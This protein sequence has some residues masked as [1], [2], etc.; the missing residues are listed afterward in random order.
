METLRKIVSPEMMGV[1][2]LQAGMGSFHTTPFSVSHS[3]GKPVSPL[4]PSCVGPRQ[5]GQ[6]SA[7]RVAGRKTGDQKRQESAKRESD[8]GKTSGGAVHCRSARR[9]EW[10]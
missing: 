1:A 10:N 5:W 8:H 7:A 9:P 6:S 2:P 3:T 4:T